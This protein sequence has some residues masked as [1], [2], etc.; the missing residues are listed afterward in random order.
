MPCRNNRKNVMEKIMETNSVINSHLASIKEKEKHKDD[1]YAQIRKEIEEKYGNVLDDYT[2]PDGF[3]V[4]LVDE[5]Y[6]I[7]AHLQQDRLPFTN[8]QIQEL[9]K[10]PKTAI[11]ESFNLYAEG[12]HVTGIFLLGKYNGR[13]TLFSFCM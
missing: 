7:D 6:V 8:E 4:S 9:I 12:K 3:P 10:M 13:Y 5:S 11:N 1:I 2:L